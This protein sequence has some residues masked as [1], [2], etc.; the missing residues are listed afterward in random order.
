MVECLRR[1]LGQI[2]DW[3]RRQLTQRRQA[4]EVGSSEKQPSERNSASFPAR[5]G[6]KFKPRPSERGSEVQ[7]LLSVQFV[8]PAG[9]ALDVRRR[10]KY[11]A[12]QS[13][14]PPENPRG[15]LSHQHARKHRCATAPKSDGAVVLHQYQTRWASL[16]LHKIL[17]LASNGLR[18]FQ[19]G[20]G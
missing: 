8:R 15:L 6:E 20:V 5:T 18:Q 16:L 3:A 11:R 1:S 13:R 19:P 10:Q 4:I 2:A 9:D 7:H 14:C 17:D 12:A